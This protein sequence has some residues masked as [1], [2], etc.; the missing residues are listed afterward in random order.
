M[1]QDRGLQESGW[2][3]SSGEWERIVQS[4]L[5]LYIWNKMLAGLMQ[6][7]LKLI[8]HPQ[9]TLFQ[10]E[11]FLSTVLSLYSTMPMPCV[12]LL[13]MLG[14]KCCLAEKAA[15]LL[16]GFTLGKFFYCLSTDDLNPFFL[17]IAFVPEN[18]CC[19]NLHW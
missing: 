16:V 11:T 5:W 2:A 10:W 18:W 14:I 9:H 15:L 19:N 8:L 3:L 6:Q 12:S 7:G 1:G 4:R 13:S 17:Y